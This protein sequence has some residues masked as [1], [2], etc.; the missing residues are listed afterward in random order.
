MIATG[1]ST[2]GVASSAINPSSLTSLNITLLWH[3]DF[4]DAIA[5]A[6]RRKLSGVLL[7][8]GPARLPSRRAFCFL[9]GWNIL[10]RD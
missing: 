6:A 2:S 3:H 7:Q 10:P 8:R 5:E 1:A 9:V 4:M